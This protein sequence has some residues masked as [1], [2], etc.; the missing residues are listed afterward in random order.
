MASPATPKPDNQPQSHSPYCSDPI[1]KSCND[2]R[3]MH[4]QVRSGQVIP[5]RKSG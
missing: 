5:I 3:E 2:L 1:C 4:E